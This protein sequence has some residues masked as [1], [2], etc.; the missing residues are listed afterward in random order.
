MS[1]FEPHPHPNPPGRIHYLPNQVPSLNPTN[2]FKNQL[3]SVSALMSWASRMV[4]CQACRALNSPKLLSPHEEATPLLWVATGAVTV[5]ETTKGKTAT[6]RKKEEKQLLQWFPCFGLGKTGI[7]AI[8]N[9]LKFI[10][11]CW[12]ECKVRQGLKDA[13]LF[14]VLYNSY[15]NRR[16]L[17]QLAAPWPTLSL[18]VDH[19]APG[20]AGG[21][22]QPG[23][24]LCRLQ[25]GPP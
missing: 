8:T 6:V 18:A 21:L 19:S 22:F 17:K 12:W 3:L 15:W 7:S 11:S 14:M 16:A 2:S 5:K 25:N 9:V 1:C 24:P 10:V 20:T 13:S 23:D 4:L